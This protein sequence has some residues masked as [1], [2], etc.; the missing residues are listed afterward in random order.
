MQQYFTDKSLQIDDMIALDEEVLYHLEKVLRKGDDCLFRLVDAE[1]KVFLCSLKGHQAKVLE[2]LKEDRESSIKVTAIISLIKNDHFELCL[3]KLTELG[4]SRIVPYEAERSV[5]KGL[6][7]TKLNRFQKIV[8]EA[9]EQCLRAS[10]PEVTDLA[11][12][13]DL[14]QYLSK[15]NLL[16]YEKED[17]DNRLDYQQ[18]EDLTYI[19]G[20]EGGF[21][22]HEVA[23]LKE[24]GFVSISLGPRILRA[25]TAA[26]YM[27]V[28]SS[29]G[30]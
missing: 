29:G 4:V 19:I 25:E 22:T 13:K 16:P 18:A 3:Q 1:K 9:S 14:S 30:R 15:V 7:A 27:A 26:I 23:K 28:I 10:I 8:Q 24:L 11:K 2:Q 12:L 21:T 20:P 5:V 6:K 17:P